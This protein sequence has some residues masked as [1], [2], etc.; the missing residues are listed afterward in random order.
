MRTKA[1]VGLGHRGGSFRVS[2]AMALIVSLLV[3]ISVFAQAPR[4]NDPGQWSRTPLLHAGRTDN[5]RRPR[6]HKSLWVASVNDVIHACDVLLT[7]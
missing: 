1:T 7:C 2:R 5:G 6:L 4:G 3:A